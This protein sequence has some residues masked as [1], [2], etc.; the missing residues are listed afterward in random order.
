MKANLDRMRSIVH[1]AQSFTYDAEVRGRM[2][3]GKRASVTKAK[4]TTEKADSGWMIFVEG[5]QDFE[6]TDPK[7]QK[8][9][10]PTT[11]RAAFN[12]SVAV[13]LQ[14]KDKNV[15]R[16]SVTD[17]L[18]ARLEFNQSDAAGPVLWDLFQ[19]TPYS[20]L[21]NASV[22]PEPSET[23]G[24]VACNVYW[25]VI[26]AAGSTP[27]TPMRAFF[28]AKNGLPVKLEYYSPGV[29]KLAPEKRGDP[30]TTITI[31]N[32]KPS[33]DPAGIQFDFETPKGFTVSGS[34]DQRKLAETPKPNSNPAPTPAPAP[35]PAGNTPP[36]SSSYKYP[37][38][39]SSDSLV[40]V[41]NAAPDFKL[42]DA[43]GKEYSLA[44]FKG[45]VLVLTFWGTW[46]PACQDALPAIQT[47]NEKYKERGVSVVGLNFEQSPKADPDKFVKD[48]GYTFLSLKQAQPIAGPY[49]VANWP[50]FYV[51]GR[52]G[53]VVWTSGSLLSPPGGVSAGN[54]AEQ[55]AYLESNLSQAIDKALTQP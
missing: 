45:K 25:I 34:K 24:D 40:R 41:G 51:I 26:P 21:E 23:V 15:R 5:T 46:K 8:K 53:K 54:H 42:K 27:A 43:D 16:T 32:L 22:Q 38:A 30:R 50:T 19:P 17:I 1:D 47:I 36:G 20:L 52:D 44:D 2:P 29:A 3:D 31:S 14:E 18:A 48:K 39:P 33:V 35:V 37:L 7:A 49:K 6:W 12:G 13:G 9:T 28:N 10:T 4:V 11:I 55:V